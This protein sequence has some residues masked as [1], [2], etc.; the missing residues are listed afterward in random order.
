MDNQYWKHLLYQL[1]CQLGSMPKAWSFHGIL[2]LGRA[3]FPTTVAALEN[4][5]SVN[6]GEHSRFTSEPIIL[7]WQRS[8][9]L[10]S[11]SSLGL[12]VC[13]SSC[14]L[15]TWRPWL[16]WDTFVI[17]LMH[18]VTMSLWICVNQL[19]CSLRYLTLNLCR[20]SVPITITIHS[21]A[22]LGQYWNPIMDKGFKQSCPS[23][24]PSLGQVHRW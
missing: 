23:Q 20:W 15:P 22:V 12:V 9:T 11:A 14:V 16:C 3:T 13:C 10:N 19:C 7:F 8:V 18:L 5:E 21:L 6:F 24:P 1:G 4:S 17:S 2:A